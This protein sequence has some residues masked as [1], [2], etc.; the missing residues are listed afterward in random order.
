MKRNNSLA[1]SYTE[2]REH[3]L[4]VFEQRKKSLEESLDAISVAELTER[5]DEAQ[6]IVFDAWQELL[7][8]DRFLLGEGEAGMYV[9]QSC[10]VV[11]FFYLFLT[12]KLNVNKLID[13]IS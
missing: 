4:V 10:R 6:E 1:N 8:V 11:E 13:G 12:G 3:L 2:Y 9:R 7:A 5:M